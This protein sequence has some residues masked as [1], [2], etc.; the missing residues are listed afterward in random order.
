MERILMSE[1]NDFVDAVLMPV[2]QKLTELLLHQQ[3]QPT[4][5]GRFNHLETNRKVIKEIIV[6]TIHIDSRMIMVTIEETIIIHSSRVGSRTKTV[7][8]TINNQ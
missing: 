2:S 5:S 7:L 3:H 4:E 8:I 6:E 1:D